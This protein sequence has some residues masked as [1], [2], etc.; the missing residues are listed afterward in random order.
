MSLPD[1]DDQ[2]WRRHAACHDTPPDVMFPTDGLGV[3]TAK[4]ICHTC[5]VRRPCAEYALTNGE[6][7]GIWGGLSERERHR[8]RRQR[9]LQDDHHH[10]G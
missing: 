4:T 1:V 2:Q 9:G 10:D 5:P 7:H 3:I 8:I 6:H